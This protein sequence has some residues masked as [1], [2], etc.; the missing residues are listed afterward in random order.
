MEAPEEYRTRRDGTCFHTYD[1]AVLRLD[2]LRHP[3]LAPDLNLVVVA[4]RLLEVMEKRQTGNARAF[5]AVT[6]R[7]W[8]G[9]GVVGAF[10]LA[11]RQIAIVKVSRV[12][13]LE[14]AHRPL[15]G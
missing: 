7:R 9:L 5:G 11:P 10:L 3:C 8:L 1:L 15:E 2:E 14:W 4:Y 6:A 12:G 13:G